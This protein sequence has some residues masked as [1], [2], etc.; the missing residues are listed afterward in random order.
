MNDVLVLDNFSL[1][2]QGP[3]LSLALG[4]GQWLAVL[5]PA[6]SGKEKFVRALAGVERAGQGSVARHGKVFLAGGEALPKR[7]TPKTIAGDF[8]P[9]KKVSEG[10]SALAATRLVDVRLKLVSS[11][12]PGQQAACE[13]LPALAGTPDLVL[14]D[15]QLD[16]LDPWALH[17]VYELLIE[18]QQAVVVATDRPDIAAVADLVLV[19]HERR[20]VFAGSVQNLLDQGPEA[21]L[22]VE[23]D[24]QKGVRALVDAFTVQARPTE[25]GIEFTAIDGQQAAARLLAEGY[26]DVRMVV[27]RQPT[28]RE[29]LLE[30][31]KV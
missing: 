24:A 12:E 2:P 14:I 28:V 23:T 30:A 29:A 10:G 31:L 27:L 6:G 17:G 22:E 18:K 9:T 21:T 11:L 20:P 26:G 5:G 4:P 1:L 7:A 15:R 13:L 3:T 8:A 16:R 19:L 25:R